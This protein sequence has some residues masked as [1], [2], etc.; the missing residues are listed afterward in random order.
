MKKAVLLSLISMI[1][2]SPISHA[3]QV[4]NGYWAYQD[5]LDEFPEQRKL[6]N[7]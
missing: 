7:A 1:G 4:L 2:F 5:F 6:T 3:T